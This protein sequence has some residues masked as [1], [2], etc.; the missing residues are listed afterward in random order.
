MKMAQQNK[1]ALSHFC[2]YGKIF[3]IFVQ[4]YLF[5]SCVSASM[6]LTAFSHG[7]QCCWSLTKVKVRVFRPIITHKKHFSFLLFSCSSHYISILG[8]ETPNL[9]THIVHFTILTPLILWPIN[10]QK[11][12][13]LFFLIFISKKYYP[14]TQT[15]LLFCFIII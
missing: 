15:L 2:R 8:A 5:L 13:W 11:C 9:I 12:L 4:F 10:A 7:S 6:T 3:T 14:P 1:S